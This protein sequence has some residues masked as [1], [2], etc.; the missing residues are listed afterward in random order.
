MRTLIPLLA[1][2]AL[3]ATSGH[4]DTLTVRSNPHQTPV[5]ELY[6]SEGC[7]SCPPADRWLAQL[8][9]TPTSDLDVLA[10]AFHVDYW[11][12]IGWKD[13]FADAK[14]T[15]RQRRLARSNRQSTIYTPEFFV[16]GIE[17]R[18]TGTVLRKIQQ[19]NQEPAPVQLVMTIDE[20]SDGFELRLDSDHQQKAPLK[21]QFVVFENELGNQVERGENA[22]RY[23]SHQRVVRYLSPATSLKPGHRHR[24]DRDP[25]W[26]RDNLG[27]AAL[28]SS[29]DDR[30]LQSVSTLLQSGP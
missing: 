17:A 12:Y 13:E 11:D 1:A 25:A 29:S 15:E 18:G 27:I 21:V 20:L 23:L 16:D 26:Q 24:I 6:T 19:A 10:L 7:S 14:F 28:V 30:Y 8:I 3:I 22:G 9:K 5:V 2:G 4:A